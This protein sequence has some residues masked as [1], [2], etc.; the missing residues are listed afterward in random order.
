MLMWVLAIVL[1][2]GF[3]FLG[4]QL[5]GIRS[6]VGL[7]GALIGLALATTLGALAAPLLPKLGVQSLTWMLVL[8]SLVGF[9]VVWLASLGAGFAAH[10]PEI[11]RAHV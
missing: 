6:T 10:R 9:S 5:G 8:P 11:G 7:I 2:G 3:A 1:V 4:F